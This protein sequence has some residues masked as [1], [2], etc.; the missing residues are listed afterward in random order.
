M[1]RSARSSRPQLVC[2]LADNSGSMR[3]DKANAATEGIRELLFECQTRGPRGPHR[4][5]FRFVLIRFGSN[6]ELVV[7]CKPVREIDPD[8]LQVLGDGGGTNITAALEMAYSGVSEYLKRVVADHPE[9]K[10][11]PVPVVILFSDGHNGYGDPSA[12]ADKLKQLRIGDDP[13]IV[14]SAGVATN[15]DQPDEELLSRIASPGCYR[16]I[17]QV[18]ELADFL[19]QVGSLGRSTIEEVSRNL[20]QLPSYSSSYRPGVDD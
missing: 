19:V 16:R 15:H 7:N 17:E 10:E 3:G 14:V 12:A 20:R 6:A 9:R 4:S 8:S 11:H 5:Y 2:V 1:K 18:D 13:V